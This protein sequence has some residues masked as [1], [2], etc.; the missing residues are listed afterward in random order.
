MIGGVTGMIVT[1]MAA[2]NFKLMDSCGEIR[3]QY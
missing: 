2:G 1:G 3:E